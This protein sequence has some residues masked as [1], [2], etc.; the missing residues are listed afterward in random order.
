MILVKNHV[1]LP[2]LWSLLL[3]L[4]L[5]PLYEFFGAP[6]EPGPLAGLV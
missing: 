6:F 4:L 5:L 3:L 1:Q 2:P